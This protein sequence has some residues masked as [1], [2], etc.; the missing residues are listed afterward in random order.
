MLTAEHCYVYGAEGALICLD[1]KTGKS[2][3]ARQTLKEFDVPEAFFGVGSSPVLEDG[4]LIVQVG[5]QPNS[6][7]VAFDA[8]DPV[9]T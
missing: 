2:V 4:R 3:W 5:G 9:G 7:V 1:R 6:G 8:A